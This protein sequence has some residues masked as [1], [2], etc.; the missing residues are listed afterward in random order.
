MSI[1]VQRYRYS[2]YARIVA[3]VLQAKGIIWRAEEH[4]PFSQAGD[5]GLRHPFGRVPVLIHD[6]FVLYETRA[7][8][9][10]LDAAFGGPELHRSA[11]AALGRMQQ[12]IGIADAYGYWP[13]VRQVFAHRVFRTALGESADEAVV[14]QGIR[15]AAPV[16]TA[17]E[18]VAAEG[19][20]LTRQGLDLADLHLA[21]MMAAFVQAP[22]GASALAACPALA[23][24][25]QWMRDQACMIETDPGLPGLGEA[26]G[27][28]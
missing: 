6:G 21:P 14:A 5:D 15:D 19:L 9:T 24:W 16:L 10:Y 17:L 22:E 18:P 1:V 25:W 23:G 7:I 28:G 12:V 8:C 11:P 20:V 27:A 13:M 4:D 2:V 3:A 26:T